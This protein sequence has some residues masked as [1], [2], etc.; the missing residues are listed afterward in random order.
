MEKL[1][2]DAQIKLSSVVSDL[3]GVSGRAMMQALIAS[4]RDPEVLAAM[5]KGRLRA[6]TTALP[7]RL[8]STLGYRSPAEYE[9]QNKITN[10][11]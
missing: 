8:H 9:G 2:E 5:A 3:F 11:A 1:L 10:V 7:A 6:K 4:Q